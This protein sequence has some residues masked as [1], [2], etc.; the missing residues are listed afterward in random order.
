MK[1]TEVYHACKVGVAYMVAARVDPTI[2]QPIMKE[3]KE[4]YRANE[5]FLNSRKNK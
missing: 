4:Q 2:P 5:L 3:L 1:I